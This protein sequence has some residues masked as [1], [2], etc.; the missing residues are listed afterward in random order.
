MYSYEPLPTPLTPAEQ[1]YIKGVQANVW[2]E[3]MP[4]PEVVDYMTWP[5]ALAVSEITWSGEDKKNYANFLERLLS[6]TT[7]PAG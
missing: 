2:T 1:K 4:A 3:Y 6:G 7:G 5:R